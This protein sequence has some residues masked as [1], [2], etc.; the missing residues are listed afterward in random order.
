MVMRKIK[1]LIYSFI[2]A[3]A[4]LG[5]SLILGK[6]LC[7]TLFHLGMGPIKD[8][9]KTEMKEPKS[10]SDILKLHSRCTVVCLCSFVSTL[11]LSSFQA[12]S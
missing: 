1:Q 4:V 11:F 5:K 12:H 8:R 7:E 3:Y 2:T 9:N 6:I 10:L